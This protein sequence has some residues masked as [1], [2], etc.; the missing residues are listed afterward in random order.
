MMI[1]ETAMTGGGK[2]PNLEDCTAT[3]TG[4]FLN[5]Q[6]ENN[7]LFFSSLSARH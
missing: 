1:D 7:G 5:S 4:D 3:Q 6:E 2:S